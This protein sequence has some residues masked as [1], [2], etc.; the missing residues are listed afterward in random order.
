M[1]VECCGRLEVTSQLLLARFL[2]ANASHCAELLSSAQQAVFSANYMRGDGN[3]DSSVDGGVVVDSR[4]IDVVTF[5]DAAAVL[6]FSVLN[7]S[8]PQLKV[9]EFEFY[10]DV[11]FLYLTLPATSAAAAAAA[12]MPAM[13]RDLMRRGGPRSSVVGRW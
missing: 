1:Q 12:Q 4:V 8:P 5:L 7:E 9:S 10:C 11:W 3:G 6:C 2:E 13:D